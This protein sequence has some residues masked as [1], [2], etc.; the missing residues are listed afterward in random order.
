ME[1][2]LLIASPQM[3]DPHFEGVVVLLCEHDDKGAFGLVINRPS[4]VALSDVI[5]N[6]DLQLDEDDDG[7]TWWGGPVHQKA[8]FVV[9]EGT[10][11]TSEGWSL[12]CSVAVS[13]SITRL[14]S[15]VQ[16]GKNFHLCLGYTGWGPHQLDGEIERGSWLVA[17][18]DPELILSLPLDE[19][20]D[21][22]LASLGL[23]PHTVWMTPIDE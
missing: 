18:L 9:Y 13:P 10:A 20:Y 15:L 23:T 2:G 21:R 5:D 14:T 22:A 3:R 17:D 6:L 16:A 7:P 19:R 8:G 12:P 11:G 4:A 1:P